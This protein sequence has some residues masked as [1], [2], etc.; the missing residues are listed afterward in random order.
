MNSPD[1]FE[2]RLRRQSWRSVPPAWRDEILSA[3]RAAVQNG[4]AP[5]AA[6]L[7]WFS[8]VNAGLSALLWPNP[9]AWA[10]LAAVW[11]V[12]LGLSFAS[13]EPI[14]RAVAHETAPP[15]PQFRELLRQQEQMLA[16][17]VGPVEKPVADR[18]KSA[19]PE[20]HSER[21]EGFAKA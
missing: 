10:G 6:R 9:K 18:P 5:R 12:V 15:S 4:S 19:T 20:P 8:R 11:L 17:L 2:E 21:E 1:E 16:E 13:R 7:S 3:A 14:P